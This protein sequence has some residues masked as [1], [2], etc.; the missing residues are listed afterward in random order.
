M[1]IS[2]PISGAILETI[3]NKWLRSSIPR[4]IAL[5]MSMSNS[6]AK[7]MTYYT[8]TSVSYSMSPM[9]ANT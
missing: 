7:S 8:M 9:M 5:H 6:R 2:I 1:S 4:T 3:T